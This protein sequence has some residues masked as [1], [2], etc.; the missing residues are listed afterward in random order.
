METTAYIGIGSNL[1]DPHANCLRA[2]ELVDGAHGCGV[3]AVSGFFRSEPVGVEDHQDWY[4]NAAAAVAVKLTAM[5]FLDVL[6]SIE[7]VM[8]RQRKKKWDSRIID[9]DLLLY[10]RETIRA[11]HL[12]VPHPLMHLRRFVLA[13]MAAVAPSV[14]HPVLGE[15]MVELLRRVP[16]D[17]QRLVPVEE[18]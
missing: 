2:L 3:V 7:T 17:G 9:L 8:G 1:G 4:V 14:V 16:E 5:E 13:P 18:P 6:L 12:T 10:G 15:T 11:P